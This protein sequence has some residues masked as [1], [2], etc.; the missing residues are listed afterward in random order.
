MPATSAAHSSMPMPCAAMLGWATSFDSSARL[1]SRWV[2]SHRSAALEWVMA[3]G[4]LGEPEQRV[5]AEGEQIGRLARGCDVVQARVEAVADRRA[6]A[7]IG[8]AAEHEDDPGLRAGVLR[9][10]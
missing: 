2:S 7:E 8:A 1:A 3:A 5:H 10:G 6:G 9:G 4:L